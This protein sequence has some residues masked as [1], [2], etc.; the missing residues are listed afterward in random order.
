M[1]DALSLGERARI[2]HLLVERVGYDGGRGTIA[3]TFHP[4]GLK[5][6][7]ADRANPLVEK[8]A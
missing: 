5:T 7:A 3:I 6:L 8:R 4:A 2:V 1:W